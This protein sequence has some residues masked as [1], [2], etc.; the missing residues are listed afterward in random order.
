MTD[1]NDMVVPEGYQIVQ[2]SLSNR[3]VFNTSRSG[4][5]ICDFGPQEYAAFGFD[6]AEDAIRRSPAQPVI[7]VFQKAMMDYWAADA[8]RMSALLRRFYR[9]TRARLVADAD[10]TVQPRAMI[11]P[12]APFSSVFGPEPAV[13][14]VGLVDHA[15]VSSTG[16]LPRAIMALLSPLGCSVTALHEASGTLLEVLRPDGSVIIA[17]PGLGFAPMA[18]PPDLRSIYAERE[19]A[20][21]SADAPTRLTEL[22]R[23]EHALIEKTIAAAAAE[24]HEAPA[25]QPPLISSLT[26]DLARPEKIAPFMQLFRDSTVGIRADP[27][28]RG[29][30]PTNYGDGKLRLLICADPP[31]FELNYG[32]KDFNAMTNGI[33]A[34]EIVAANPDL[35]GILVNNALRETSTIIDRE[36]VMA[37]LKM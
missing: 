16:P 21:P 5:G 27:E 2:W 11:A 19:T 29:V 9:A 20:R 23:A 12:G 24:A 28:T 25:A 18:D 1:S 32:L 17:L 37:A 35:Q 14:A 6:A 33:G 36:T 8:P 15:V 13:V 22:E 4:I 31:V 30:S 3:P 7:W 34:C 10:Q 26:D